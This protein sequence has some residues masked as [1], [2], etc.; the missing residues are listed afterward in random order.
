[1][2]SSHC[3]W[4]VKMHHRG[5]GDGTWSLSRELTALGLEHGKG[6]LSTMGRGAAPGW[7]WVIIHTDMCPR[8]WGRVNPFGILYSNK[9]NSNT[10][11]L[12]IV[13]WQCSQHYV[14][15]CLAPHNSIIIIP[16]P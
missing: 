5:E 12:L 3:P 10:Y 8:A 9:N 15:V 7:G 11:Q 14:R 1:M 2:P 4:V 6:A 16:F 13:S